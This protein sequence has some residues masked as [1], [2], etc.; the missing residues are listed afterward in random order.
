MGRLSVDEVACCE[1]GAC[2]RALLVG[3]MC[4]LSP[5]VVRSP[6]PGDKVLVR[7]KVRSAQEILSKSQKGQ[8]VAVVEE[9]GKETVELLSVSSFCKKRE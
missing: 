6:E 2:E 7:G 4:F 9:V 1:N 3:E 5:I 8:F